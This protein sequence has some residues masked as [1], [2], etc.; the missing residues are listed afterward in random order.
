MNVLIYKTVQGHTVIK[1]AEPYLALSESGA[2]VMS[3]HPQ[4]STQ[5]PYI[6]QPCLPAPRIVPL[7]SDMSARED[8]GPKNAWVVQWHS[9]HC[10]C[11]THTPLHPP[12][13]SEKR[14]V[15]RP[16]WMFSLKRINPFVYWRKPT[17]TLGPILMK[18]CSQGS[19]V[20]AQALLRPVGSQRSLGEEV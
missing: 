19:M 10:A 5:P 4:C 9:T 6:A 17:G 1:E 3:Q 12:F 8:G 2:G 16:Q 15:Y 14:G 18:G 7:R 20:P 13:T 11:H